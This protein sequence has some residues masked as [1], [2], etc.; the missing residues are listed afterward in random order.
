MCAGVFCGTNG[1]KGSRAKG[2]VEM[3]SVCN[4]AESLADLTGTTE[5]GLRFRDVSD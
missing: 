1:S 5:L 2:E 4:R 3:Q